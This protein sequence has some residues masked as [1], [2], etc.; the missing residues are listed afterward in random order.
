MEVSKIALQKPCIHFQ[1]TQRRDNTTIISQFNSLCLILDVLPTMGKLSLVFQMT[2]IFIVRNQAHA[3]YE[4]GRL[5]L[6]LLW[7]T[8]VYVS[9]SKINVLVYHRLALEL[10]KPHGIHVYDGPGMLSVQVNHNSSII[11]FSSFQAF[12]VVYT[13][14]WPQNDLHKYKL[15]YYS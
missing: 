4:T 5:Y 14:S 12:I 15:K 9:T 8:K 11:Y 2:D 1:L 7:K 6:C 13:K 10:E 3:Q